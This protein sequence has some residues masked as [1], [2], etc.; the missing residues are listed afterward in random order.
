M[1]INYYSYKSDQIW[2][3]A[4][5]HV[6]YFS[7]VL[8]P[9]TSALRAYQMTGEEQKSGCWII[10]QASYTFTQSSV[11]IMNSDFSEMFVITV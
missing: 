1:I 6:G 5:L 3:E 9:D 10:F 8:L 2:Q 11:D 4:F 7:L